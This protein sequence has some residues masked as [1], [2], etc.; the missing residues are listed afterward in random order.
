VSEGFT[1]KK[2]CIY[3]NQII[4]ADSGEEV[5]AS[6]GSNK[7]TEKWLSCLSGNRVQRHFG[8]TTSNTSPN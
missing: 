3:A 8:R 5:R 1:F 6:E 2:P 4:A 7:M